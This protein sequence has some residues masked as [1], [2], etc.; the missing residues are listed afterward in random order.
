MAASLTADYALL[1][2]SPSATEAQLHSAYRNQL[3]LHHPD[4]HGGSDDGA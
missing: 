4:R 2:C 3:K 1:G